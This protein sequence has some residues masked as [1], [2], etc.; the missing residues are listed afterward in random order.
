MG[1]FFVAHVTRQGGSEAYVERLQANLLEGVKLWA[2]LLVTL[3]Q[4]NAP[5]L[6]GTMTRSIT[7]SEP[8]ATSTSVTIT[9]GPGAEAPYALYTELAMYLTAKNGPKQLGPIS[10]QKGS[11]MP[12]LIPSLHDPS[13]LAGGEAII[14]AAIE[15][16]KG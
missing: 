13:M 1:S 15:G 6:S 16:A 3:A 7:M 9:V 4:K 14:K 2:Q 10:V 5:E 12:W 11:I 8:V